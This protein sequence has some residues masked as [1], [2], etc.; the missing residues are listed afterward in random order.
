MRLF[1]YLDDW[2]VRG[3]LPNQHIGVMGVLMCCRFELLR[4]RRKAVETGLA[5]SL[6][7]EDD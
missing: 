2:A 6:A 3:T 5:A 7:G 4:L 1:A